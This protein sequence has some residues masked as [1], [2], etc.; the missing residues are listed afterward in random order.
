MA[1]ITNKEYVPSILRASS[2]LA[3]ASNKIP[4]GEDF[5]F[6]QL[7]EE[8]RDLSTSVMDKLEG[9]LGQLLS[10]ITPE[11]TSTEY[12]EIVEA[13]DRCLEQVAITLDNLK[14]P[15]TIIPKITN[16]DLPKPVLP[17]LVNNSLT[18]FVPVLKAKPNSIVS[19]DL[20][21]DVHPYLPELEKLVFQ[22]SQ[23]K[24]EGVQGSQ[25]LCSG[26]N[27]IET[28]E[29]L[30]DLVRVL[31][32]CTEIAIDLEHHNFRSYL[33]IT[34]LMQVSTRFADYIVDPFPIW[35]EMHRLLPVFTNPSIVKVLHGAD[36]DILWL[37][38][39]F[40]LYIVNLFDTG[41]AARKLMFTHFGLGFL[42]EQLCGVKTDKNFQLADWRI[43]PLTENH[44]KYARID[45][46]F[47]LEIYDKV[48]DLLTSKANALKLSP[49]EYIRDVFAKSKEIC[50]KVYE[51]PD[52]AWVG[53]T[54]IE[55]FDKK[56]KK[57]LQKLA[58]WRDS[59][60][61]NE[62]ESPGFVLSGRKIMNIAAE[63]PKDLKTLGKV[64][65]NINFMK[66]HGESLMNTLLEIQ[67]DDLP[68]ENLP[69]HFA[70]SVKIEEKV[71]EKYLQ[72]FKIHFKPAA[73]VTLFHSVLEPR[74]QIED[75]S[76]S[77]IK[78]SL[79]SIFD[80]RNSALFNKHKPALLEPKPVEAIK[81]DPLSLQ[82]LY[83][84]PFKSKLPSTRKPKQCIDK[85]QKVND[86]RNIRIG[87]L[88]NIELQPVKRKNLFNKKK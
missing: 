47:L 71:E 55:L 19:L 11:S 63:Q 7:D 43:R 84:I 88:D 33:G 57:I 32:G 35:N 21:P 54:G 76:Y 1:S 26:F 48:K 69:K 34:C 52:L 39:D 67:F 25:D 42:L 3:A 45:T 62:D 23:L 59:I 86:K 14:N 50:M 56:Q 8:I 75:S 17:K 5:E 30:I 49:L 65:Q 44:L 79:N 4:S 36:S 15:E 85:K 78:K 60:A 61:R 16:Y 87:W 24:S 29:Q 72:K 64:V 82:E 28:T 68:D 74:N 13:S 27:Y 20:S 77:T 81:E 73:K 22:A 41:Q 80:Q 70:E 38:R 66:K 51:K 18:P 31:E 12:D 53:I 58:K 2:H 40:G 6:A 9:F 83:E 46:H 37:Q 10:F